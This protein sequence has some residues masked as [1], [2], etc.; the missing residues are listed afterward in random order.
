M[1]EYTPDEARAL[2]ARCD[3]R[4]SRKWRMYVALDVFAFAGPRQNAARHL[5]WDD[6]DFNARTV[7][8]EAA[9]R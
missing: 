7:R 5:T 3:S 8:L 6:I 1:P 9:T 4:D 2:L